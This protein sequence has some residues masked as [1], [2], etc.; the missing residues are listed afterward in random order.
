MNFIFKQILFYY[1][2]LG[3][4]YSIM[5]IAGIII[6]LAFMVWLTVKLV[7]RYRNRYSKPKEKILQ[8][9][10]NVKRNIRLL[11]GV[12]IIQFIAIILLVGIN[13]FPKSVAIENLSISRSK[14]LFGI[15]ISHYQGRINWS[16]LKTTHHPVQYIF[17][18]ATMGVDGK[19]SRFRENW[20]NAKKHGYLRGAYHYYR[21]NENSTQQFANFSAM[22][23]LEK[24]DFVPILDVEQHSKFGNESLRKG[25]L[26]WLKLAEQKYGVKPVVY[27]G[28]NFYNSVLKGH[29]NDYPL[30]IA[31]YS[32]KDRVKNVNW[33]FHQFT[34][35]VRIKGIQANVDGND[36]N[37]DLA[38][39][40]NMC[41]K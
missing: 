12:I 38:D 3:P 28:L 35:Q 39:L 13:Y 40:M 10:P 15:D 33:T 18:R 24:G 20:D 34:E 17:I 9:D 36:F 14:Y 29:I 5:I 30:W 26:N 41:I 11:T 4:S 6:V 8:S 25:V 37:G 31:A 27:T 16:E 1:R 7:K 22:V 21:P 32:G 19:D 23:K 2:K